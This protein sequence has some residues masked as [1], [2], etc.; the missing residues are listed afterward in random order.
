MTV[1]Y[2]RYKLW[3]KRYPFA[4]AG[5]N[6]QERWYIRERVITLFHVKWNLLQWNRWKQADQS[7]KAIALCRA[8]IFRIGSES[9]LYWHTYSAS[10]QCVFYWILS[11][12]LRVQWK[13]VFSFS[14]LSIVFLFN[15]NAFY[16]LGHVNDKLVTN[17]LYDQHN[18]YDRKLWLVTYVMNCSL[19]KYPSWKQST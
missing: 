4:Q 18:C 13:R 1:Y 6:S 14:T 11:I 9:W 7:S 17:P 5:K 15:S 12:D 2:I 10:I 19:C 3:E 16:E 8:S